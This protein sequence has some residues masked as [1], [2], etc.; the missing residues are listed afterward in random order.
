[1]TRLQKLRREQNRRAIAKRK[2]QGWRG[3][4]AFVPGEVYPKELSEDWEFNFGVGFGLTHST[5][6]LVVKLILGR[7]F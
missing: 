3:Y 7:R 4:S 1:M 6:N 5:D 2:A